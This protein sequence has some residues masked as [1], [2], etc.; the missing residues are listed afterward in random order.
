MICSAGDS[1]PSEIVNPLKIVFRDTFLA[2]RSTANSR[3]A[4]IHNP[5]KSEEPSDWC[6]QGHSSD[7]SQ[8]LGSE[9]VLDYLPVSGICLLFTFVDYRFV[10]ATLN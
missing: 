8:V 7:I 2:R 4:V 6:P 9:V 10:S 1:E 5:K 3:I